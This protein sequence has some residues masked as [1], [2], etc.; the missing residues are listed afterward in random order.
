MDLSIPLFSALWF[1]VQ[2]S[3][4]PQ[5]CLTLCDPMDCSRPGFPVQHQFPE[6]TQTHVHCVGDAIQPSH[7][8]SSPSPPA[9]NLSQH[10]GLFQ[11]ASSS[12]QVA[13][14]LE[15]QLQHLKLYYYVHTTVEWLYCLDKLRQAHVHLSQQ[16]GFVKIKFIQECHLCSTLDFLQGADDHLWSSLL[17]YETPGF[18]LFLFQFVPFGDFSFLASSALHWK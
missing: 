5:S 12:H 4:G 15:F 7:P 16:G 1:S 8:L 9:L 6:P 18:V 2:F 11:W 17:P 14:E 3:S 10:Q 13:K